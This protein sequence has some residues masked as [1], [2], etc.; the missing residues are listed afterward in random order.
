MNTITLLLSIAALAMS[1]G[2]LYISLSNR[3]RLDEIEAGDPPDMQ[4]KG[5]GGGGRR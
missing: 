5:A 2:A 1:A 4:T 3:A